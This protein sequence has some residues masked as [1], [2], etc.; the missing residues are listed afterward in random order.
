VRSAPRFGECFR[1]PIATPAARRDLL[2]GGALLFTSLPGWILNMGH[3]LEVVYRVWHDE[4]EPFR[5]FGPVAYTFR[6]GLVALASIAVNLAPAAVCAWLRLWIPAAILFLAGIYIL[7]G[8]QTRNA[9]HRDASYL[10]RPDRALRVA[11]AGG[12]A[13]LKAWLIAASAIGLSLLGLAAGGIGFF[14]TSVWAWSV[15]G[16]AFTRALQPA[17]SADDL[18]GRA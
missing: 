5:G 7:P 15:V 14:W 2:V 13:Y 11:L 12:R 3:R 1:F 8:G 9:A 10:F 4:P 16:Y 17:I 6:R 18:P